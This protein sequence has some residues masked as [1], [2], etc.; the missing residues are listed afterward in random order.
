MSHRC[1]SNVR[2]ACSNLTQASSLATCSLIQDPEDEDAANQVNRKALEVQEQ[3]HVT[4]E[5]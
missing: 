2:L 4:A 1:I 3:Q 5:E